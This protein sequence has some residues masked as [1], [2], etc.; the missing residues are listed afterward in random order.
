MRDRAGLVAL[1]VARW[2]WL[3]WRVGWLWLGAVRRLH[4]QASIRVK[5]CLAAEAFYIFSSNLF[6]SDKGFNQLQRVTSWFF[7]FIRQIR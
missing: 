3:C 6:H 2:C 7:I 4:W 5:P 1:A